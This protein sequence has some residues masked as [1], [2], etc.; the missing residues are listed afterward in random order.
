MEVKPSNNDD[1]NSNDDDDDNDIVN[2]Q[3]RKKGGYCSSW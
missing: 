1:N 3:F 2:L